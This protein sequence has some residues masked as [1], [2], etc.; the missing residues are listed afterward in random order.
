[1]LQN[2]NIVLISIPQFEAIAHSYSKVH[3][4]VG[5]GDGKYV[6][7]EA[8]KNPDTLYVGMDSNPMPMT[9]TAW[10]A[11]RKPQK[12]GIPNIAL[13][14]LPIEDIPAAF[15]GIADRVTVLYPWAKLL[16][17]MIVP[18][19]T[20]LERIVQIAK[21]KAIFELAINYSVFENQAY[22]NKLGLPLLNEQYVKTH[23]EPTY[24][25]CSLILKRQSIAIDSKNS[26]W[27]NHLG[28]GSRR[29]TLHLE[30]VVAKKLNQISLH[31]PC[32]DPSREP[33][34]V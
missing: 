3:I 22:V 20:S 32:I 8:K 13:M 1:M 23:L 29:K 34:R 18:N 16:K 30:W 7:R 10:K 24:R 12:G 17:D 26:S 31:P 21:P 33:K 6:Y 14:H 27:G 5:T 19:L 9:G 11:S 25:E 2:R 4:D 28:K 15:P